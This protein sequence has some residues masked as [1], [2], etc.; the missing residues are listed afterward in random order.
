MFK[1]YLL[2]A[3]SILFISNKMITTANISA[4]NNDTDRSTYLLNKKSYYY[5]YVPKTIDIIAS[6][7]RFNKKQWLLSSA[8]FS[9][10]IA[11]YFIEK[12]L[13]SWIQDNQNKN[14]SDFGDIGYILAHP[15][16]LVPVS[17]MTYSI[18][19]FNNKDRLQRTGIVMFESI[20]LSGAT[21]KAIKMIGDRKRP[22]ESSSNANFDGPSFSLSEKSQ[23]FPSGHSALAFAT[24]TSIAQEYKENKAIVITSYTIATSISA[25]R[26][27]DNAHWL[28]DV[29]I[30]SAI[31][32]FVAKYTYNKYTQITQPKFSISPIFTN[33][34]GLLIQKQF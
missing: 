5:S 20:F 32:H 10:A 8:I 7:L 19:Y 21:V 33:K 1:K 28:S 18:G 31:G 29:I 6:P 2:L 30:G 12:D 13:N 27:F 11:A 14:T 24:A 3:F 26:L 15:A 23:S 9:S 4:T 34:L 25:S 17:V 16:L 22:S